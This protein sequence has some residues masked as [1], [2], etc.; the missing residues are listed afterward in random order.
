MELNL[1]I[2]SLKLIK[3][4]FRFSIK[5]K[6]HKLPNEIKFKYKNY[7]KYL[8]TFKQD[9]FVILNNFCT[10]E[11]C[12]LIKNELDDIF[13]NKK[14]IVKKFDNSADNRLFN[15]ENFSK[16]IKNFSINN[17]IKDIGS[18]YFN[19][20]IE[21]VTTLANKLVYNPMAK[22]G[23]GGD[24]HRDN[25]NTE[26]KAMLYLTDVQEENGPLEIIKNSQ[27]FIATLGAN[28]KLKNKFPNTRFDND[29]IQDFIKNNNLNTKLVTGKKG[30]LVLFNSSGIHRGA[31][32]KKG[33]RYALT[34]Y[35][36]PKFI[37]GHYK[38]K[39]L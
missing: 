24:W 15:A 12:D 29:E 36:Y 32:I 38:E 31:P 16:N 10:S 14:E 1:L 26:I 7:Q 11:L 23:S 22:V 2:N 33:E 8:K 6:K 18:I 21:S 17:E 20:E 4:K 30:T 39:Y 5:C 25:Y 27:Y 28:I 35:Y 3:Y 9:G 37:S 13:N 34:N 19:T